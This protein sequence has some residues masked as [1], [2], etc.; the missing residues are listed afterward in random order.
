MQASFWFWLEWDS[1]R[2]SKVV[3]GAVLQCLLAFV[4]PDWQF[5]LR[6]RQLFSIEHWLDPALNAA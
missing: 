6:K 1:S 5:H 3:E 2:T 4:L